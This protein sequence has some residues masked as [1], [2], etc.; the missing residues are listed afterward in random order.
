[1]I[2]AQ[3]QSRLQRLS[4]WVQIVPYAPQQHEP[5]EGILVGDES[6]ITM[7]LNSVLRRQARDGT[8]LLQ[9]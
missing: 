2:A 4:F 5:Q 7:A 9:E 8:I 3:Q 1:M 6:R